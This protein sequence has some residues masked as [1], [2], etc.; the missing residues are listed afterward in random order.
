MLKWKLFM[1]GTA[2]NEESS[3]KSKWK[4]KKKKKGKKERKKKWQT[5]GSNPGAPSPEL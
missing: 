4:K 2:R 1:D 5:A 3:D